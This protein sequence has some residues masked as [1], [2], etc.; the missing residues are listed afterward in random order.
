MTSTARQP[1]GAPN[2]TGGQFAPD[3]RLESSVHLDS[4]AFPK[5]T[6]YATVPTDYR[7]TTYDLPQ[8]PHHLPAPDLSIQYG[9]YGLEAH[10][11]TD[12]EHLHIY[13]DDAHE[14]QLHWDD[15]SFDDGTK[16]PALA[17]ETQERVE[18]FGEAFY[19]RAKE[20]TEDVEYRAFDSVRTDIVRRASGAQPAA[21]TTG[22]ARSG[23]IVVG[24]NSDLHARDHTLPAWPSGIPDPAVAV[25]L[26]DGLPS[27]D[28][29][30]G[31]DLLIV[32]PFP[33]DEPEAVWSGGTV[34]DK[35]DWLTDEQDEQVREWGRVA[36]LRASASYHQASHQLMDQI[37]HQ[38]ASVASGKGT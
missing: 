25:E 31:D 2:S 1:A 12:G 24:S 5:P 11:F 17:W 15:E 37:A 35:P 34:E 7:F 14:L 3:G 18:E 38:L 13:W 22:T 33:D 9:D 28:V 30:V 29:Q 23:P 19:V 10:L 16:R 27:V 26:K 32:A 21:S 36:Y 8:W 4:S 6:A 20:L